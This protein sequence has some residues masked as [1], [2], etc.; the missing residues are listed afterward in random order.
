MN[1]CWDRAIKYV[2]SKNPIS[3]L[4]PCVPSHFSCKAQLLG[5]YDNSAY[6]IL[7]DMELQTGLSADSLG[8]KK[9]PTW[10]CE[11]DHEMKST[12]KLLVDDWIFQTWLKD[13]LPLDVEIHNALYKYWCSPAYVDASTVEGFLI[14]PSDK[15]LW[16]EVE[17]DIG[18]AEFYSGGF[19]GWS[20]AAYILSEMNVPVD[21]RFALDHDVAANQAFRATYKHCRIVQSFADACQ[22]FMDNDKSENPLPPLFQANCYEGWWMN[23]AARL[24][25]DLACVSC[26]CPPWTYQNLQSSKSGLLSDIGM[27]IPETLW[28][29]KVL[30]CTVVLFENDA[31]LQQ[32]PQWSVVKCLFKAFG[33]VILWDGVLNLSDMIPQNRV[34]YLAVLVSDRCLHGFEINQSISNRLSVW[35]STDHPTLGSYDAIIELTPEWSHL[36]KVPPD[37]MKAFRDPKLIPA[38]QECKR[39]RIDVE[40]YRLRGQADIF[41]TIMAAYSVQAE[42]DHASLASSFLFG[43]L[44]SHDRTWIEARYLV[45]AEAYIL[46]G[47]CVNTVLP[48]ERSAHFRILGNATATPHALIA[49]YNGLLFFMHR[50]DNLPGVGDCF[51]MF[52]KH[53]FRASKIQCRFTS[54]GI[55]IQRKGYIESSIPESLPAPKFIKLILECGN[56]KTTVMMPQNYRPQDA[57]KMINSGLATKHARLLPLPAS[58]PGEIVQ[59][60]PMPVDLDITH[61]DIGSTESDSVLLLHQ[62]CPL[63]VKRMPHAVTRWYGFDI[64][65]GTTGL[66]TNHVVITSCAGRLIAFDEPIPQV[67]FLHDGAPAGVT[68][69]SSVSTDRFVVTPSVNKSLFKLTSL[70]DGL[71]ILEFFRAS[72]IDEC[73]AAIGWTI[74]MS[75][76]RPNEQNILSKPFVIMIRPKFGTLLMDF[77]AM[78]TILAT[79]LF[80]HSCPPALT[81]LCDNQKALWN[82]DLNGP[83]FVH[84]TV[85]LCNDVIWEGYIQSD[86]KLRY[87][88]HAWLDAAEV[89]CFFKQLRF[90]VNGCNCKPDC[91]FAELWDESQSTIKVHL[92]FC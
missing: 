35:P 89:V 29:T 88:S 57:F 91:L 9:I 73:L 83:H 33:W 68:L 82:E 80:H 12:S 56:W 5:T 30:G 31:T 44:V 8:D 18:Y 84:A 41:S 34:R 32:H 53:A 14:F 22:C 4:C 50:I 58:W 71:R 17:G 49:W 62:H 6:G 40:T 20:Q 55:E 92:V 3:R 23:F 74:D 76:D 46:M 65:V 51:Q 77:P 47:G 24:S 43:A 42:C 25:P 81:A 37:D 52:F 54:S 67:V 7:I 63:I 61:L 86:T 78:Q 69:C 90:V 59:S 16:F 10:C 1:V 48:L 36:A 72:K 70:P 39:Q 21:F 85:K 45:A 15:A 26:P 66:V 38:F 13:A 11:K 19:G 2:A 28:R 27:L 64:M 79:R 60:L 75:L 87:F